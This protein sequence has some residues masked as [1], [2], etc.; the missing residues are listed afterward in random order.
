MQD[1]TFTSKGQTYEWEIKVWPE[2]DHN[3][4]LGRIVSYKRYNIDGVYYLSDAWSYYNTEYPELYD[5]SIS[6]LSEWAEDN[7]FIPD[8]RH[9]TIDPIQTE[10]RNIIHN[11][12]T[13]EAYER[14]KNIR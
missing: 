1:Y 3:S 9:M 10:S 11:K 4:K 6:G 2:F 14:G 13:L 5:Q 12:P 8:V 7:R